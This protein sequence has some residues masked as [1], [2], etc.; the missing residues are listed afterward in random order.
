MDGA[1]CLAAAYLDSDGDEYRYRY[2]VLCGGQAAKRALRT[3]ALDAS[4]SDDPGAGRRVALATYA[5]YDDFIDRLPAYIGDITRSLGARIQHTEAA[6]AQIGEALSKM[7]WFGSRGIDGYGRG[8]WVAVVLIDGAY[9]RAAIGRNL[10]ALLPKA[11]GC[12]CLAI[13]IPI[14]VPETGERA[15]DRLARERLGA[16]RSSIFM[17]RP[18]AVLEAPTFA[19]ANELSLRLVGTGISLQA[20]GMRRRIAEVDLIARRDERIVEV[21]PELSFAELAGEPLPYAK[22][23]WR[24]APLRRSLLASAGIVIPDELGDAAI[25]AW[26]AHRIARGEAILLPDP[27]EVVADG[28]AAAIRV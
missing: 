7:R 4:D 19:A 1:I 10:E 2:A 5:D 24:G 20:Y 8:A 15:A 9:A 18:K 6:D 14:G 21:H 22:N 17:T 3:A 25:A 16:R 26:S 11:A 13:D 23:S 27:P 28:V 12:S